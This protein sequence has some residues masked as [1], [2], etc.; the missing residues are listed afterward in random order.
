MLYPGYCVAKGV[1]V[2]SYNSVPFYVAVVV[3]WFTLNWTLQ[4][5]DS[6]GGSCKLAMAVLIG[7]WRNRIHIRDRII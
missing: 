2:C 3:Q 7:S 5:A 4:T 1:N 6:S